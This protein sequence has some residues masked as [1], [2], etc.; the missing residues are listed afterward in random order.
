[1]EKMKCIES[2]FEKVNNHPKY[3]INQLNRKVKLKHKE[4]MNI[5]QSTINQTALS[6]Q[7]KCHFLALLYAYNKG[8]KILKSMNKFSSRVLPCIVKISIAY[9]G[10]KLSSRFQLKDQMK[11]DHQHDVVY[12][13]K[14][15]KEQ[16]TEDYMGEL[17][18]HL[19]KQVKD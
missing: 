1:M 10:T 19:I 17:R 7:D 12:Y 13:A 4:N 2:T 18:R 6:E 11:K 9:P 8:E 16:C 5:E 15:P 14:C 3:V